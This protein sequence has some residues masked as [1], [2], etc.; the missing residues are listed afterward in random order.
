MTEGRADRMGSGL[1]GTMA[2]GRLVRFFATPAMNCPYVDGR[3]ERQ[4]VT[5]LAGEDPVGLHD[6]LAQAGFRRSYNIA[7][8]PACEGCASCVPVRVRARDFVPNRTMRR[9]AAR[10]AHLS[11]AILPA[12]S[13]GEHYVLF[14]RYQK[15]RHAEGAMADME[16]D[17]YRAM[18]EDSPVRTSLVEFRAPGGRLR[19]VAITDRIADGLS[20]VYSFYDPDFQAASPGTAMILWHIER[21]AALGLPHVYLGYWVEESRK[22]VY[23]ARFRPLERLGAE[24]WREIA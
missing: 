3:T 16:L 22:M 6:R 18:V 2:P 11:V 24:G 12:K 5:L 1:A 13:L 15:A 19:G 9:I 10:A 4:I 21:A 8:R 23:K 20:L 17:D 7:Y 14:H